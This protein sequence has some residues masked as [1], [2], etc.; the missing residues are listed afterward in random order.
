MREYTFFGQLDYLHEVVLP[1]T[2]QYV[3]ACSAAE[4]CDLSGSIFLHTFEGYNTVFEALFPGVFVFDCVPLTGT[5]SGYFSDLESKY[6]EV[7]NLTHLFLHREVPNWLGHINYS[8]DMKQYY[9]DAPIPSPD[10]P[11]HDTLRSQFSKVIVLCLT[12]D[13]ETDEAWKTKITED[14]QVPSTL[15]CIYENSFESCIV[16]SFVNVGQENIRVVKTTEDLLYY[17]S[18]CDTVLMNDCGVIDLAKNCGAKHVV[19]CPNPSKVLF[20]SVVQFNPFGT[21]I[22]VFGDYTLQL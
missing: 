9:L 19:V 6:P 12:G 20:N 16:P 18:K 22:D 8:G 3:K 15:C 5:R 21:T 4:G 13:A 10:L 17:L 7:F 2:Q 11:D 1:F 14:L